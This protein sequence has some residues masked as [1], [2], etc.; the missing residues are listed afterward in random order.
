MSMQNRFKMLPFQQEMMILFQEI[1]KSVLWG[2]WDLRR[3]KSW[4]LVTHNLYNYL[5]KYICTHT[6]NV[7]T[8]EK[9]VEAYQLLWKVYKEKNYDVLCHVYNIYTL[10][11]HVNFVTNSVIL[12]IVYIIVT[13][14]TCTEILFVYK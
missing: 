3:V 1:S 13:F 10:L 8:E 2:A 12:Y 5:F 14:V 7:Q 11:C 4:N 9:Q 6:K